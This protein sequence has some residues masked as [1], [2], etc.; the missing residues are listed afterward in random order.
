[1]V[2]SPRFL[3]ACNFL[4]AA[5]IYSISPIVS[6]FL[7]VFNVHCYIFTSPPLFLIL[8]LPSPFVFLGYV[9][10][11]QNSCF[12]WSGSQIIVNSIIGEKIQNHKTKPKQ[13]NEKPS[14]SPPLTT[15]MKLN[16]QTLS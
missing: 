11:R 4:S 16:I 9:F 12:I 6:F 7:P 8:F 5:H 1:M 3:G 15:T 10:W 13:T 14:P 2:F